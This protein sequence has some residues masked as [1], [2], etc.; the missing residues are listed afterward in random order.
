[1]SG[2]IVNDANRRRKAVAVLAV[3]CFLLQVGIAPNVAVANGHP[4][5][6]LV[7]AGCIALG[8]GGTFA[9]VAG[10]CAGLLF[11]L[12]TTGPVGLMALLLT[13]LGYVLGSDDRDR[14]ADNMRESLALYAAGAAAVELLYQVSLAVAGLGGGFI[15]TVFARWLPATVLDFVVFLPFCLVL[16]HQGSGTPQLGNRKKGKQRG[17]S[18]KGLH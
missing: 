14:I 5:F 4:N 12:V 8:I 10:F 13:V 11:D 6:L 2:L 9:V 15:E 18:T 17:Y 16:A 1:M 3:L 7:F